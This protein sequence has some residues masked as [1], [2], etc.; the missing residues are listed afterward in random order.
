MHT[1]LPSSTSYQ[2]DCGGLFGDFLLSP[3]NIRI[4]TLWVTYIQLTNFLSSSLQLEQTLD[5]FQ[6]DLLKTES[7]DVLSFLNIVTPNKN[8]GQQLLPESYVI[9]NIQKATIIEP[10]VREQIQQLVGACP[11]EAPTFKSVY[12]QGTVYHSFV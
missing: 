4:A 7:R 1:Q 11:I 2:Q 6:D 5:S 10:D 8:C 12:Y 3:T 9:G